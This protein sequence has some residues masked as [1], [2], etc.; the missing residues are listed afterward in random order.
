[1]AACRRSVLLARYRTGECTEVTGG[2][3]M[4]REDGSSMDFFYGKLIGFFCRIYIQQ[5]ESCTIYN[6][7]SS[8]TIV[9]YTHTDHYSYTCG[10][11]EMKADQKELIRRKPGA[12]DQNTMT[13]IC[14]KRGINDRAMIKH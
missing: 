2:T 1:M 3:A 12:T 5:Y 10:V 11:S 7:R 4:H 9:I 8:N 13:I 14:T 6:F